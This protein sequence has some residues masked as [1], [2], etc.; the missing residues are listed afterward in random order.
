LLIAGRD[1]GEVTFFIPFDP[2]LQLPV[3]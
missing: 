2:S 1:E 3:V